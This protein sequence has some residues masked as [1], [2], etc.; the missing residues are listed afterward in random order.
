[1]VM[2][3][4]D[5]D[6]I[7]VE[8]MR[9]RTTA[10]ILRAHQHLIDRLNERGIFP[11]HQVLD[12]EVSAEYKHQIT[13]VNEMTYQLVPPGDHQRNIVEKE[14]QVFKDHFVANMCGIDPR[15]P[16]HLWCQFLTQAEKTL[17]FARS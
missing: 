9:N 13:A 4:Y 3:E 1:M 10:E 5:S 14:I 6:Y 8:P 12:N 11:M 2:L 15:C 7:L 17:N 16:L